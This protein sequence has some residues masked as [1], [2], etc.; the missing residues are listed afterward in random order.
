VK[1][2]SQFFFTVCCTP[3]GKNQLCRPTTA[4]VIFES[5]EFRQ[6]R[7]DWHVA[8]LVLVPDHLH[9]LVSFPGDFN[10]VKLISDWKSLLARNCGIIWQRDFFDHRIRN[11]EDWEEKAGYIRQNPVRG[12]LIA[13]AEHWN[14]IWEPQNGGPGRAALPTPIPPC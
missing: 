14:F 13:R 8:L 7:L 10:M 5:V 9:M 3:R 2:G 11:D 12:G 1:P 6:Q 4:A